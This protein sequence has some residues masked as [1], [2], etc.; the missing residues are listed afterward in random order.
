MG[1]CTGLYT[2]VVLLHL[3]SPAEPLSDRVNYAGQQTLDV[4][5]VVQLRRPAV[6][7]VNND[8]LPVRLV[9]GQIS[10]RG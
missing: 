5:D 9:W 3:L 10:R 7:L 8:N 1:T 6:L 2:R 4:L